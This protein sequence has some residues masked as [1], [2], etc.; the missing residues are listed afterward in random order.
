[1]I[2]NTDFKE[3]FLSWVEAQH[4]LEKSMPVFY[5]SNIKNY[6]SI[7]EV[8]IVVLPICLIKDSKW[9]INNKLGCYLDYFLADL[10]KN[11]AVN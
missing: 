4:V 6:V 2:H 11:I 8:R 1:M 5:L 3:H 10:I 7:Q 9:I